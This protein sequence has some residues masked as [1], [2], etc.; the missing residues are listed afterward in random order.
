M[1][2]RVLGKGAVRTR[3]WKLQGR[4][5]FSLLEAVIA[6]TI[7][8]IVMMAIL[9]MFNQAY[10]LYAG[11]KRLTVATNLAC[12]KL[13]DFKAQ[14][15]DDIKAEDPKDKDRVVDGIPFALSWTVSDVD[16]DGDSTPDMVG[17]L[18][19]ISLDVSY[20][21]RGQAHRVSMATM[22]TGKPE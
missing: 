14:T 2:R 8:V 12:S 20:T 18:V 13:A 22:T 11:S 17:N 6:M 4:E 3:P 9:G 7:T 15:V 1:G 21:Y 16:V 10:R 19:K 5:G